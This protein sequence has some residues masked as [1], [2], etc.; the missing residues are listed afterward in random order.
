MQVNRVRR[1]GNRSIKKA[2]KSHDI[3]STPHFCSATSYIYLPKP[4]IS[5]NMQANKQAKLAPPEVRGEGV[6]MP[7]GTLRS[8]VE[9]ALSDA[10]INPT[11]RTVETKIGELIAI[12]RRSESEQDA[13]AAV[14]ELL[15]EAKREV[16]S[17]KNWRETLRPGAD[18]LWGNF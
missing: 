7:L 15:N 1:C 9:L 18:A 14:A 16:D 12:L 5:G 3:N 4:N 11:G 10:G 2:I 17:L 8:I 13:I 6:E